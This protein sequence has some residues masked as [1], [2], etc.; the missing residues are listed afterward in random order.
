MKLLLLG[1]SYK[2]LE[3][4][5]AVC[6]LDGAAGEVDSGVGVPLLPRRLQPFE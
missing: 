5:I 4:Q 3:I 6:A 2:Q 1:E